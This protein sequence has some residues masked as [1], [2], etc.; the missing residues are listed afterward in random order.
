[1]TLMIAIIYMFICLYVLCRGLPELPEQVRN[2]RFDDIAL[3]LIGHRGK[4]ALNQ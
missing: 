4:Q 2:S 3:S 1:M